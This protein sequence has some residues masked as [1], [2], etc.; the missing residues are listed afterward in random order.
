MS[1]RKLRRFVFPTIYVILITTILFSTYQ[2]WNI[3]K[4]SPVNDDLD[5][6]TG[7]LKNDVVPAVK[8]E[9]DETIGRPF[10]SDKVSVSK[11]FYEMDATPE[12]QQKSLILFENIYMQNTG[13]LYTSDEEF[14]IISVLDGIVKNIKED[15]IMGTIV[16]VEYN[17][18]LSVVYE[19][20]KDVNVTL[21][22]E[23][24]KGDTI[25]KSGNIKLENEKEY[26]LHL[27]VYKDGLL[28]N[29]ESFYK[30]TT[31]DFS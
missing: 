20:I 6:V 16:E 1:K 22:E 18:N 4:D 14:E 29:P 7:T 8:E 28:L 30:M 10:T 27:E 17:K 5:Y 25:A 31:K 24:K 2:I 13:V 15:E 26:T 9:V 21:N 3:L 19:G 11:T 23:I 12:E